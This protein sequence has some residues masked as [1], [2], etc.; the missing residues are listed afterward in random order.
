MTIYPAEYFSPLDFDT[1]KLRIASSTYSIHW[2]D[3]S[4]MEPNMQYQLRL[5]WKLNK[6]LPAAIAYNIS[7]FVSVSKFRGI[8]EAFKK[9]AGKLQKTHNTPRE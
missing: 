9:T 8:G 4:W 1:G 5:N 6:F 2:F 7:R 3:A